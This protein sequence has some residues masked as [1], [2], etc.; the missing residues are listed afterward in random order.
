MGARHLQ[1]GKL[2]E[3]RRSCECSTS[4][5]GFGAK[6]QCHLRANHPQKAAITIRSLLNTAQTAAEK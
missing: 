4:G 6:A 1:N 5:G 3:R 2:S